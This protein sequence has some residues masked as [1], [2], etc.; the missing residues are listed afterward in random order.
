M[1]RKLVTQRHVLDLQ[2]EP[3]LLALVS[4]ADSAL[5]TPADFTAPDFAKR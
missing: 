4:T 5:T 2:V 3:L 1:S